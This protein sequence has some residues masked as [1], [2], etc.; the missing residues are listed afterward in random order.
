M[1]RPYQ[2]FCTIFTTLILTLSARAQE[3]VTVRV[4]NPVQEPLPFS[5]VELLR[6]DSSV[7]AAHVAD[8]SG[9]ALLSIPATGQFLLR[10][11]RQNYE[12]T[13]VKL[14]RTSIGK[15]IRLQLKPN[16]TTL[17]NVTVT[18]NRPMIKNVNGKTIVSIDGSINQSGSNML[19][20]LERTPGVQVD[21]D[22]NI[23][24]RGR[25]QVLVLIDGK[26]TYVSGADLANLLEG[27]SSS[28]VES[29]ELMD[30]PPASMDAAGN[31]GVINIRTKK[32]K[33]K[34]TNANLSLSYT[35]GRYPKTNDNIGFNHRTGKI[36]FF[37]NYS[38]N[39]YEGYVD[40]YA[41]RTYF[42]TASKPA[43]YLEQPT[44]IAVKGTNQNLRAGMDYNISENT[45]IGFAA[46]GTLM[47]RN[48][49]GSGPAIWMDENRH[50]DSSIYTSSQIETGMKNGNLNLNF[51]HRFNKRK[52]LT[53]DADWL[54][55]DISNDQAF[56][57]T[58]E[59]PDGYVEKFRGTLPSTIRIFA[60]KA[61]Y[62]HQVNADL[63]WAAGIKTSGTSTDNLAVFQY[64]DDPNWV[65]DLNRSNH[66]LYD[67]NIYA[68]YGTGNY[69]TG[70][71]KTEAGLRMEH[72]AYDG[73]QLGNASGKD[74]VFTRNYTS[75][76]PNLSVT[77][78]V[79]SANSFTLNAGRRIDRPAFQKLNPFTIILNKYTY[80]TGN[81]Y[82]LPQYTWN[83]E[84]SHQYKELLTTTLGYHYID[85]YFTQ[86]FYSDAEGMII[87]TE[88]NIGKMQDLS[89][90]VMLTTT[91]V[92]GWNLVVDATMNHKRFEGFVWKEMEA[93][94][95]QLNLSINNQFRFNKNWTA[96]LSGYYIT[97]NQNDITEVL[98]PTGQ[99]SLGVGR[100]IMKGKGSLKLAFRDIFY[101][102]RMA[103]NT[104]FE[105]AHEYFEL[106]RDT[107]VA[108][109]SFSYRFAKGQKITSR[110]SGNSAGEEAERVNTN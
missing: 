30:H 10:A 44:W 78:Q 68:V 6:P 63:Q 73:N 59:G 18:G 96:E 9:R 48:R 47:N 106:K 12:S 95:T 62:V 67:E 2:L 35:Q 4:Q 103:G 19:E 71:W 99:L 64:W 74:S 34:G 102:Q 58:K 56:S 15:G 45:S 82:I 92:K 60:V 108:V 7:L 20:V 3:P 43:S 79:D 14:D 39:Y 109:L 90:S 31:A 75:L 42:P 40:L 24:L 25:P 105:H 52:T 81:P 55:Y 94:I 37:A 36:N 76:F 91:P 28:T 65:D 13:V 70:K 72:T 1:T 21:R 50:I 86:L 51:S 93:K 101:T 84:A 53:A 38:I 85:N 32:L 89:L 69:A 100:Q 87:Y 26:Q 83:I 29:I 16:G 66:F 88:G 23:S 54:Y 17:D 98:D 49:P 104:S 46:S 57:N 80:Q 11:S 22:G 107:R 41:F 97:K 27:M 110:K 8:S 5:T 33:Q 77:Y 61:D